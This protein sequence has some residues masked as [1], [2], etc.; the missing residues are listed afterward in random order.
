MEGAG[1]KGMKQGIGSKRRAWEMEYGGGS[2]EQRGSREL[3][4]GYIQSLQD[5]CMK[6]M[7]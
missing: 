7:F 3:V 1:N 5:M 6:F 2:R 4:K